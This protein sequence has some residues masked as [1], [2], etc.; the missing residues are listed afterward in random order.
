[1]RQSTLLELLGSS[2][3]A[4]RDGTVA[5]T[6]DVYDLFCGAGGFSEG[7]KAAGC[8]V[9]FACDNDQSALDTHARNH[10]LATHALCTL[11][12]QLPFPVDGRR[13]HVHGSPPC[14]RFSNVNTRGRVEGDRDQS[15][16][17]V[18][19]YIQTALASGACSWSMEQVASAHVLQI[20]ERMRLQNLKHMC[21]AVIDFT[22]L[23]VPQ[24]RKRL[25]VGS[26]NL[27]ANLLR[28]A[29]QQRRRSVQDVL[30]TP[31]GTHI[32]SSCAW[33]CKR[34][35]AGAWKYTRASIND[36]CHRIDGPSPTLCGASSQRWVNPGK[37]DGWYSVLRV[38]EMA[39]IQTF[40][41]T[42]AFP[43]SKRDAVRQVVN[44]V[45]PLVAQLILSKNA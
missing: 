19:W 29:E 9:V 33:I 17:L 30:P 8:R 1:M 2:A 12:A 38:A 7:A 31:R 22:R 42:Y 25:I 35:V 40:P 4:L 27:I 21:Y 6:L 18:Q 13:F 36:F 32:R 15:Q 37:K 23:G 41:P 39:S 28:Q 5:D 24:R 10:P 16:N 14:Q 3:S 26:P 43:R 34:R 20:V 44:A 45:P 11:P